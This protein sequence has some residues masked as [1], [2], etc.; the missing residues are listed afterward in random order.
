MFMHI[1]KH[2]SM[3][4]LRK[5]ISNAF[6]KI[7]DFRQQ[8]KVTISLHDALMSGLACMHFQDSSL[9]QFQKRLQE[10]QNINN[11]KTMFDVDNIPSDT[12]MRDIIDNVPSHHFGPIFKDLSLRLQ[13]NKSLEQYQI[14]PGQY[15]C[16]IDGSQFYSSQEI[17]CEHCLTKKHKNG[18]TTYT[19]QI[20]QGG[21]AHPDCSE[22]IPFMPEHIANT[23]GSTKQ[24]C[25]MNAAKRF[26]DAVCEDHPQM[27]FLFGGDSLFSRQ[28]IIENVLA[29]QEHYLFAA[30]PEDHIVMM[31][32]INSSK[33]ISQLD[34]IDKKSV[35][36]VFEW[37]NTVLLNGNVKSIFVNFLRYTMYKKNEKDEEI[38]TYRNSWITDIN[39]SEDNIQIL[40]RAG[41]CRWKNENELFNV[42]KNHGYCM[43]H[44]YGHGKKNL[45]FNFY[46]LTL[47]AFTLH[48]IFEL[49]DRLYQA[50]RKKCGSKKHLWET[51]RSYIKIIV[52][53]TWE[54]LLEFVLQP[55][56][57]KLIAI[58]QAPP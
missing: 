44:N 38:I 54:L 1:K 25:E 24:D 33:K 42:M 34:W 21:I 47:L 40:V 6:E 37:E 48:Q 2:L 4:A 39:I 30:K 22:V 14:F 10:T 19:H 46:L 50:C 5:R 45:A 7:P 28:P 31:R 17:S 36:H 53:D 8:S 49:T 18:K 15:Y 26:I 12:Q 27:T 55:N 11:L 32:Y 41:R 23:D 35:R 29:L 13:R 58:K 16:P 52:F 3:T 43:E 51:I 57:Y 9:L 56:N 20:L